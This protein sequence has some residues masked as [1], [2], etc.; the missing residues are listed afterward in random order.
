MTPLAPAQITLLR[1]IEGE[2]APRLYTLTG[3]DFQ[4]LLAAVKA[5][6]QRKFEEHMF[7]K[8]WRINGE[9][10]RLLREQEGLN[11]VEE[12]DIQ[13]STT[14]RALLAHALRERGTG[15]ATIDLAFH[16]RGQDGTFAISVAYIH[17]VIELY[18]NDAY[19]LALKEEMGQKRAQLGFSSEPMPKEVLFFA[20]GQAVRLYEQRIQE[21]FQK[22]LGKR[23]QEDFRAALAAAKQQAEEDKLTGMNAYSGVL[24]DGH[25]ELLPGDHPITRQM[26]QESVERRM[27]EW[28]Q[29]MREAREAERRTNAPHHVQEWFGR[30]TKAEIRET[31]AQ[32]GGLVLDEKEVA[33]ITKAALI[34]RIVE[35]RAL[36][37]KLIETK[38]R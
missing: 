13:C 16:L 23:T 31:V 11:V 36:C 35:D 9:G 32:R 10:L 6:P 26:A 8:Y 28:A 24:L 27:A 20:A 30:L 22:N 5:L 1:R 2:Y 14:D 33:K 38:F 18:L 4:A 34:A 7:L 15:E 21:V 12:P 37:E 25:P 3:K 17:T 19:C 29:A